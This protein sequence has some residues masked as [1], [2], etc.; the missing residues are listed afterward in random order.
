MKNK[1]Q[2]IAYANRFGGSIK[3]LTDLLRT[4]LAGVYEGVHILP[5]YTPFDGADAGFDPVDHLTVDPRLGTW[6]DI[7]ELSRTHE[8][9]AD[10]I[11]N[12][13]SWKTKEF[14]DVLEKGE[15]SPYY[16]MF[17][18]MSSVFP[19]GATEEELTG[20]YRPRPGLP[21]TVYSLGGRTRLVW[22]TFTA[23][24]V[25]IDTSTPEGW[26]Y[27]LSI[28]DH[29]AAAGISDVRL[30]AVGYAV[31][32]AGGSCFM[33]PETFDFIS[34]LTDEARR[35]GLTVLVEVHSHHKR[36][37]EIARKVD[38]VY[39]FAL[40]A[41]LLHALTTGDAAPLAK[42]VKV[43]P[44]NDVTVLDTH[45][46]IGVIDVGS[47]QI[48]RSQKGLIPDA[49]VDALVK[50]IDRNT[51]GESTAATGAAANNLDLYQVNSTYYSALGCDDTKYLAARAVQ[52]FLPG[53]PQ[54]YY[55]G[56]MMTPNDMDLLKK[57]GVGRDINR[58]YYTDAEINANLL[59]PEVQAL[60]ALCRFRNSL[61]AFDGEF[62]YGYDAT[63]GVLSLLWHGATTS[64]RLDFDPQ[65][66]ADRGEMGHGALDAEA[67][68]SWR[69][70]ATITWT[71]ASGEHKT[72]NLVS[73]PPVVG[74][75]V[76]VASVKKNA[77][78]S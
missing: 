50:A 3:G 37:V 40:P 53:V 22:T 29:Q 34:R 59:R 2:L 5:F 8:V 60:N 28:L 11:V 26:N 16:S 42:W 58:H 74:G 48:D 13:V 76:K 75:P 33:M 62:S 17:L 39:D 10:A 25:D 32:K 23:Q 78:N 4:K 68:M 63:Y 54:V 57:T 18:T 15:K 14:Q 49:A 52:F 21:F 66:I 46:G 45:D 55:T 71:D 43:R 41:L 69:S 35:R 6:A 31:K 24:Q 70:V 38:K 9:M 73:N 20:I 12:H 77:Q 30:D 19:K 64:A 72:N 67:D 56:A 47:D 44:N 65:V 1:V 61:D 7:K 36:Q 51:H 27:I